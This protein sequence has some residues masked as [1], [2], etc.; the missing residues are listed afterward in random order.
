M[1]D[2][3]DTKHDA[4][5][6]GVVA[7]RGANCKRYLSLS[8]KKPGLLAAMQKLLGGYLYFE[9]TCK[10]YSLRFIGD[11]RR[12]VEKRLEEASED[13]QNLSCWTKGVLAAG[14]RVKPGEL[15]LSKKGKPELITRVKEGLRMVFPE[16]TIMGKEGTLSVYRAVDREKLLK[17]M[18]GPF[19][20]EVDV[21]RANDRTRALDFPINQQANELRWSEDRPQRVP[22]LMKKKEDNIWYEARINSYKVTATKWHCSVA[23]VKRV[24]KKAGIRTKPLNVPEDVKQKIVAMRDNLYPPGAICH[25]L[26]NPCSVK[27]IRVIG[28]APYL[29]EMPNLSEDVK[30][31]IETMR[32]QGI[33]SMEIREQ[34]QL[35]CDVTQIT[36]IGDAR[37][38]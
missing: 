32:D 30:R 22:H 28:N 10:I 11:V 15:C 9:K 3:P 33:S 2:D 20:D 21:E 27:H 18:P 29:E 38:K 8:D 24:M 17:W 14:L 12:V 25:L 23:Q 6:A 19:D 36:K 7:M 34:L 31:Q 35:S 1:D 13:N 4:F 16:M 26:K 37:W 5:W